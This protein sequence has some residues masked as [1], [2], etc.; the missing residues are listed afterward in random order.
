MVASELIAPPE[1]LSPAGTWDCARAAVANGTDAIYFGLPRFNARMRAENFSED[2]IVPLMRFLH[3]HGVRG[4]AAFNVLV[5]T[6]EL[7]AAEEALVRLHQAGVDAVIVQDVGIALLAHRIGLEV[8]AST[9]MTVTSPEGVRFA[10]SLGAHRVV[11]ARETSLRELERFPTPSEG[12]LPLEVFVHGALCVA[13]SG[14]CLTSE[15]L[16]QRSANRG[17]CAQACRLPYRMAVDGVLQDLGDRRYLLSP[18]DLAAVDDIPRLIALGV[19]SFKIEGRLKTAEYVAAVTRVYRRAIDAAMAQ[20]APHAPPSPDPDARYELEMAFSRGLYT[21]WM[22]GVDHQR[23]VHA[24]FGKKRGAYAGRVTRCG[25]DWIEITPDPH[26]P[27]RPVIPGDGIA[28]DTGGDTER[29]QGGRAIAVKGPR[30]IFEPGRIDTRRVPPGA[31]IWKTDDP[32]LNNLWRR[33]FAD[34]L[35]ERSEPL[36]F[37][38]SGRDGE[39]LHIEAR[40]HDGRSASAHS[41]TPLQPALQRPLT[42]QTLVAQLGRLGG[43]GYRLSNLTNSIETKSILPFSELGRLRRTLIDALKRQTPLPTARVRSPNFVFQDLQRIAHLRRR[44]FREE[45]RLSQRARLCELAVLCR[46]PAQIEGAIAGGATDLYL[47]FEDIR[48]YADAVRLVHSRSIHATLA[49]PR[50]QKAGEEGFFKTI[51]NAEPDGIL[52]RNLGAVEF[53]RAAADGGSLQLIGDFSLN[54]ANPISAARFL[55]AGLHRVTA[56]C[57][58]NA[59]ELCALLEAAPPEWFE[60]LIHQHMAMFHMEHCVFAAFLSE[61]RDYRD[62][63]RPCET[64]RVALQ[65]RVGQMHPLRADVGCRNTLF[66]GRAQS[67]AEF[68]PRLYAAGAK[69]FRVELLEEDAHTAE[70]LVRAYAQL[71]AGAIQPLELLERISAA[72]QLGVT[73]GTLTVL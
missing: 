11:L 32:R 56:A 48:R 52:I 67:A 57:D 9:Q 58:L 60:I 71:L 40:C 31:R 13:Y 47:D 18:Q 61:G 33:S 43:T 6:G 34:C 73:G 38:V 69:R 68:F 42:D 20:R 44:S 46:T 39:P 16:G 24:R 64:H 25:R 26:E 35:P 2:D 10:K 3:E 41:S 14:Q 53:F 4:F 49:T 59:A 22:H 28:I 51:R 7:A 1:L 54:T 36:D 17:E 65:D 21:G 12:G 30:L 45:P 63:G 8:H 5:F 19:A 66:N 23:L 15:S 29:E 50:I 27:T 37:I 70:L 55:D 62:C 72:S